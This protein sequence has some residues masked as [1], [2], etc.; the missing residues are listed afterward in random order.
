M[1]LDQMVPKSDPE[2]QKMNYYIDWLKNQQVEVSKIAVRMYDQVSTTVV[3]TK[4]IRI[5]EQILFIPDDLILNLEDTVE[6]PS[7]KWLNWNT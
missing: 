3:A 6:V 7:N 5:D 1:K 4:D 2:R